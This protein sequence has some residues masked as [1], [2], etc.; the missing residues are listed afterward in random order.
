V[1]V[2]S[3]HAYGGPQYGGGYADDGIP[4]LGIGEDQPSARKATTFTLILVCADL[5]DID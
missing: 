3:S 2:R 4:Q 1:A 5:S